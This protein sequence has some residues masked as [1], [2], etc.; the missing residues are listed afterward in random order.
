MDFLENLYKKFFV[1]KFLNCGI[2]FLKC[3]NMSKKHK[4][5]ENKYDIIQV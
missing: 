5:T 4:I 3:N 1:D 2:M